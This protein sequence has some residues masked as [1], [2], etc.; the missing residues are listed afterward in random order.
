[1]SNITGLQ[2]ANAASNKITKDSIK[3]AFLVLLVKKDI[4][5]ITVTEIVSK[6]GVSRTAFYKN[7]KTKEDILHDIVGPFLQAIDN[8]LARKGSTSLYEW[9]LIFFLEVKKNSRVFSSI[10]PALIENVLSKLKSKNEN[11]HNEY[12]R[13]V[14]ESSIG[15][16]IYTWLSNPKETP[17]EIATLCSKIYIGFDEIFSFLKEE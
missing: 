14:F 4:S 10:A 15:Y 11:L 2:K 16:V 17:E 8:K 7:Y 1:M 12:Q 13:N 5:K 3:E 9:F 6:A